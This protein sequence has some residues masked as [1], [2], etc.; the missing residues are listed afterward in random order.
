M[1]Y[2][3]IFLFIIFSSS[4]A[5]AESV[6]GKKLLC[7]TITKKDILPEIGLYF[8]NSKRVLEYFEPL[9][10]DGMSLDEYKPKQNNLSY[11]LALEYIYLQNDA[12]GNLKALTPV[13]EINRSSLVYSR[14]G[15][16]KCE[17]V[18]QEFNFDSYF[19]KKINLYLKSKNL[20][21]RKI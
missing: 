19:Q 20:K 1:R 15:D 6:V 17:I 3:I 16:Y 21:K 2:L 11:R 5:S 18:S 4:I 10:Y 14:I 7:K 12:T 13:F 9:Y 8:I